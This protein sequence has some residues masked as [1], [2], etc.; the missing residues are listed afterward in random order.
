[1]GDAAA[2]VGV[3]RLVIERRPVLVAWLLGWSDLVRRPR[4]S[5][6]T[7]L[8]GIVVL[9]L[10]TVPSMVAAAA[11]WAR[12]RDVMTD[13]ATPRLLADGRHLGRRVWLGGLVLAGVGAAVR[14]GGLDA[15]ADA[16]GRRCRAATGAAT[17]A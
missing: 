10:L 11:G 15:R 17:V 1:M 16:A 9:M 3:R 6:A 14:G 5:I 8:F 7:A 4:A 13:P 12:V 2:A